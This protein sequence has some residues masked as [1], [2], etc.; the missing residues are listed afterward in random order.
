MGVWLAVGGHNLP[1]VFFLMGGYL[2]VSHFFRIT[3]IFTS[4]A[5]ASPLTHGR[6]RQHNFNRSTNIYKYLVNALHDF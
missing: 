1:W 2:A 3:S 4:M 5:G 6:L